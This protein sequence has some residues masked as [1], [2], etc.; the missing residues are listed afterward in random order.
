MGLC[1]LLVETL[2][3]FREAADTAAHVAGPCT[4][5]TGSC[6]RPVTSTAGQFKKFLRLPAF[7]GEFDDHRIATRFV[8]GV[9]DG[10]LHEAETRRCVIWREEP[11]GRIVEP[12]GDGYIVNRREFYGALKAE[13][14]RY[15]EELR[16]AANTALRDR[17]VKKMNDI[18]REC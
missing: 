8:R 9:R 10:I 3:S 16:D 2:Q 11:E 5:P 6:I 17:F 15:L 14:E 4:Y 12:Q 7:G 1:C 13:F 18:E